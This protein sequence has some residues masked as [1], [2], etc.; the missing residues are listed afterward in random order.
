MAGGCRG[1]MCDEHCH[2]IAGLHTGHIVQYVLSLPPF[3]ASPS[4]LP[5]GSQYSPIYP[6]P[7][8]CGQGM[9]T[10]NLIDA[11]RH[12]KLTDT[13]T[14]YI[15][16]E[17]TAKSVWVLSK[18]ALKSLLRD[19]KEEKGLYINKAGIRPL[20]WVPKLFQGTFS[21]WGELLQSTC[22]M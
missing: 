8:H 11:C 19:I 1:R 18:T 20:R 12:H 22:R 3:H 14:S 4:T 13:V 10:L 21:T 9:D 15:R 6:H 5:S 7:G 17:D 2:I 16:S